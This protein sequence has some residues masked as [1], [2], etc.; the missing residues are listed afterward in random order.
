MKLRLF[1]LLGL[2][3]V[4]SLVAAA[5]MVETEIQA[6]GPLGPLKGAMLSPGVEGAPVVVIIPGSG[7]VNRDGDSPQVLK[8]ATYKLLA[9]ELAARGIASVRIDKRGLYTSAK[10]VRDPNAV[11]IADYAADV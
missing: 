9:G 2:A 1:A 10:A 8:A 6:P 5:D 4:M 3:L 11:T 7:P